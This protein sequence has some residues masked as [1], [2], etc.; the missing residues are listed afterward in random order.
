MLDMVNGEILRQ[1]T[2]HGV[3]INAE[4]NEQAM[5]APWIDYARMHN[6]DGLHWGRPD[7]DK[8]FMANV[9]HVLVSA[10]TTTSEVTS[11]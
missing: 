6:S 2:Q 3:P 7:V 4:L 8:S 1:L 5:S 11:Y 10:A 9:V